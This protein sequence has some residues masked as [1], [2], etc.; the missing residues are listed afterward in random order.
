MDGKQV[1]P[2]VIPFQCPIKQDLKKD[3]F[4]TFKLQTSPMQ[5]MS[6]TYDLSILFFSHGTAKELFDL[7]KNIQCICQGKNF[8]DGLGCYVLI[9]HLLQGDALTAFNHGATTQGN[10]TIQNFK[11]VL[12]DL[13][14]HMLPRCALQMQ[15]R[16]MHHKL[17]KPFKVPVWDFMTQLMEINQILNNFSPFAADQALPK[18]EIL[19]I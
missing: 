5:D 15:G 14:M 16:F 6:P 8:M 2:S 3:D 7:I 17:Y 4:L 9:R 10:E 11:L 1:L 18:N 12:Q 19:D 13:I